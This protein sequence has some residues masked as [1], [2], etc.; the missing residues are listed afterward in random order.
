MKFVNHNISLYDFNPFKGLCMRDE[1]LMKKCLELASKGKGYVSPNPLVGCV[2]AKNNNVIAEGYH[3]AFGE[4]HAEIGALD[5]IKGEAQGTTLFVNLE[6]C[7]FHG[8][9]PP[10]IDRI[11]EEKISEVVIGA[12]DPNPEVAGKGINALRENGIKVRTKILEKE[13]VE[14]N[15]FFLKWVHTSIPYITIKI[16]ETSD[17]F[18]AYKDG[19]CPNITNEESRTE[20]HKLR[21]WH[22]TVLVGKQTAKLDNPSLTV[23]QIKGRQPLRIVLDTHGKLLTQNNKQKIKLLSDGYTDKTLWIVGE[24]IEVPNQLSIRVLKVPIAASGYIDLNILLSKL[25]KENISSILVE[26]GPRIWEAFLL[27]N[28]VDQIIVFTSPE[29]FKEGIPVLPHMKLA[30]I[31]FEYENKKQFKEDMMSRKIVKLYSSN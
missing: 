19:S 14:L 2:I 7:C 11:I 9:T 16:A 18:V 31:P 5:K 23:R 30:E 26:G 6:P 21:A 27:Q 10:C 12:Q 25:G 22:D 28:L 3:H 13:C 17:H 24:D 29:N 1:D 4:K 20:V 15:Q 8:K